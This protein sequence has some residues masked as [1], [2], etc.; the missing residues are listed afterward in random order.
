MDT[1][2]PPSPPS[3]KLA[4]A[5]ETA[6]QVQLI[7]PAANFEHWGE[8][9]ALTNECGTSVRYFFPRPVCK[10]TLAIRKTFL[11]YHPL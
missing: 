5:G 3:S 9:V 7:R 2:P 1:P 11:N 8:G 10:V 4:R 6:V